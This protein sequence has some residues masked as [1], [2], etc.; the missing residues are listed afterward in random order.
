MSSPYTRPFA[1]YYD[2]RAEKMIQNVGQELEFFEF[3][4]DSI[5][6]NEV[7]SILD[8]GCGTGR[9]YIPLMQ[10]GYSVTGVDQSQNMLDTLRKKAEAA[11]LEPHVF[12]KD[13]REVD[14]AD[15]FDAIICMNT[16]F[17]YLLADEDILH[18][19]KAFR[20]AL[21]PGGV[22]IIDIMNFIS[23]LGGYKENVVE[24]C[25]KNGITFE[26]AVRHSVDSV[27]AIWNHHEFGIITDS[28]ETITYRELHRFRMLNY[29]EMRRFL[30]E[31]GFSDIRCFRDFA[32]R[33]EIGN[34]SKRLIFVAV[35]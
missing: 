27:P 8:V 20:Q 18:A 11:E 25:V 3:V 35:K 13:M 4:F 10:K 19:L 34:R 24:R 31:A 14:L 22:A 29:N 1:E 30:G 17:M 5:V 9:H 16:A 12:N 7:E 2:I 26:W 6:G 15:E 28:G 23:L 21:R 33:S 32:D